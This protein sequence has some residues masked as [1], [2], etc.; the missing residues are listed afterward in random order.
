M[1]LLAGCQRHQDQEVSGAVATKAPLVSAQPQNSNSQDDRDF[2]KVWGYAA[3]KSGDANGAGRN[4]LE[5]SA[6]ADAQQMLTL[7]AGVAFEAGEKGTRFSGGSMVSMV[8]LEIRNTPTNCLVQAEGPIRPVI[9]N[10]MRNLKTVT[11][12]APLANSKF[13]YELLSVAKRGLDEAKTGESDKR[14]GFLIL[15]KMEL[16]ADEEPPQCRY[17]VDVYAPGQ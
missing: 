11:G 2:F 3:P 15:R 5:A 6:R 17:E 4:I 8:V 14:T 13:A 7:A 12:V 1:M 16:V 9:P 10:G